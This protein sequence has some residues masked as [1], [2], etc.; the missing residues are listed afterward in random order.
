MQKLLTFLLCALVSSTVYSQ[1]S[2]FGISANKTTICAPELVNFKVVNPIDSCSY[3]WDLGK[4]WVTGSQTAIALYNTPSTVDIK[5]RISLPDGSVCN[6]VEADMITV[7]AKPQ[8]QIEALSYK[9]CEGPGELEFTDITPNSVTRNWIIDGT[10]YND[11][12]ST[13]KHKFTSLGA[14]SISLVVT[15]SFGC[16]GVLQQIDTIQVYKKENI[17]FSA[18]ITLGCVPQEVELSL[19]N[20]PDASFDPIYHWT[21]PGGELDSFKGRTPSALNYTTTGKHHVKLRVELNNGCSYER[22]KEEYLMFGKPIDLALKFGKTELCKNSPL[23]MKLSNNASIGHT[24]WS[25]KGIAHSSK[26]INPLKHELYPQETGS[27]KVTIKNT[28]NGCISTAT[29]KKEIK[30]KEVKAA[31]NSK[32]HFHCLIPHTVHLDNK[33]KKMDA[34]SLSY[35]WN[36]YKKDVLIH[37]STNLDDSATFNTLPASYDVE[38]I[39][40]GNNGCKDTAFKKNFIYQDTMDA[41]FRA[42]PQIGCIGQEILY[43]NNTK[44][45]TFMEE[46]EFS[47]TFYNLDGSVYDTSSLRDPSVIYYDTG[48]Y[49]TELI[50]FNSLGCTD[51]FELE[52]VQII[53]PK[54]DFAVTDSILCLGD[55]FGIISNTSP[56]LNGMTHEYTLTHNSTGVSK[57]YSGTMVEC[58]PWEAG[59]YVLY[60]DFQIKD[61]CLHKRELR[62][63]VNG[64]DGDIVVD[65]MQACAPFLVEPR[66]ELQS[67][68]HYGSPDASLSY[69]WSVDPDAGATISD[70]QTVL[71]EITINQDGFYNLSVNIENSSQCK[72]SFNLEDLQVGVIAKLHIADNRICLGDTLRVENLSQ[73]AH[74]RYRYELANGADFNIFDLGTQEGILLADSGQY[75]LNLIAEKDGLCADTA[76]L[77]FELIQVVADFAS[78]DTFLRCAPVYVQ[79]ENQSV[80]YDS[81]FWDFGDGKTS[82]STENSAGTIYENNSTETDGFDVQLIATNSQGCRDT[83]LKKDYV[84]VSGPKPEFAMENYTAC[85]SAEV[86]F[87][88]LTKGASYAVIDYADGSPLDSSISAHVYNKLNN[89]LV[90][91]F[92]PTIYASDDNGCVAKYVS[93]IPVTLYAK[94]LAEFQLPDL[95]TACVPFELEVQNESKNVIEQQWILNKSQKATTVGM[96]HTFSAHGTYELQLT[97]SNEFGCS[98]SLSRTFQIH[99]L[100]TFDI[101]TEDTLCLH[102]RLNFRS[103]V[104]PD[105]IVQTQDL[106]L[107]WNFGQEGDPDNI[108]QTEEAQFVYQTA[109]AK[110]VQLKL[111][112]I[113]GCK[114]SITTSFK[115][116]G[117]EEL[118]KPVLNYLSFEQAYD[119]E[120]KHEKST[121]DYFAAY[122]YERSDGLTFL[123]TSQNKERWTNSFDSKPDSAYCY[124]INLQDQCGLDGPKSRK[125]CFIYLEVSSTHDFN[126]ELNWTPYKG[127]DA[128]ASYTI[129]RREKSEDPFESI[130]TVDGNVL[131][132]TDKGLCDKSYEYYVQALNAVKGEKSNSFKVAHRPATSLN[133]T[134]NDIAIASVSNDQQIEVKWN[135]SEFEHF[136]HFVLNK[137]ESTTSDLVNSIILYDT[138]YIDYDVQT[139]EYS[140]IYTVQ[141]V[142]G[143]GMINDPGRMGKTMLLRADYNN[144]NHQSFLDWSAYEEWENGVKEYLISLYSENGDEIIG[145]V[146]GNT[147]FIDPEYH[148]TL[149]GSYCYRIIA[150][151]HTGDSSY[152]NVAC[153]QGDPISY[154]PNAFSP[155]GDGLND[156]FR[157][158]SRFVDHQ[159]QDVLGFR[160]E[161]YNSWGELIFRTN[162]LINGWD[163][164]YKGVSCQQGAYVYLIDYKGVNGRRYNHKGTVT[165]IR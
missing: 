156:R 83:V 117:S 89:D 84:I 88:D 1:C 102:K 162:D 81:L 31:F 146:Q 132:Y 75:V 92:Y 57:K 9:L 105:P 37:T 73:N 61:A 29:F 129:F 80:N 76:S 153:I 99:G 123:N 67:N 78:T 118:E 34:D 134:L 103:L 141:E 96:K 60:Y 119:L 59:E 50:G 116:R 5:V 58:T 53:N 109:G 106:Q 124:D 143:C 135:S 42:I 150:V 16:Q 160:M 51:T 112:S 27:L 63:Y 100:P 56:I 164:T 113:Y 144:E 49:S 142:D 121:D 151:S 24:Q 90:E 7:R 25:F 82:A 26:A 32:D 79:F 23:L 126:N 91:T 15:D 10:N 36:I 68:Y 54:V 33:S 41:Q 154:I 35:I 140:Y 46:D 55:S 158:I 69:N 95:T 110:N 107:E 152:S 163:G 14:K 66:F 52:A 12:A 130:A 157:P 104:S 86:L 17:D 148:V 19:A 20:E 138:S 139:N 48:F 18:N 128:V 159:A 97:T 101:E 44:S 87:T 2:D 21:L 47:W 147:Q 93:D 155:N 108:Q 145:N 161:I 125:H 71:P 133:N 43:R 30:V 11:A 39:A 111:S 85:H 3:E 72:A 4:G 165:I 94:P 70:Y 114:D 45:S 127:W 115:L 62:I 137:Y 64:I 6:V 98:D 28:N 120:L 13:I 22:Q 38:L 122:R 8:P 149:N 77:P 65:S 40:I 136:D 74:T 131:H